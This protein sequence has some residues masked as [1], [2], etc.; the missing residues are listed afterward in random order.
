MNTISES[1]AALAGSKAN[2][3]EDLLL[4]AASLIDDFVL[5]GKEACLVLNDFCSI[6]GRD[7]N[8]CVGFKRIFRIVKEAEERNVR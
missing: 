6:L 2:E 4:L 5:A 1:L 3:E 7:P 8:E